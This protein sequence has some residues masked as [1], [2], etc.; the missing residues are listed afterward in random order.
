[1]QS[2][3]FVKPETLLFYQ[4]LSVQ[5]LATDMSK[6]MA[7]V[8]DLKTM[9]ELRRVAGSSALRLENNSERL[10]VKGKRSE[11]IILRFT[12]YCW[13]ELNVTLECIY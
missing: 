3:G 1:M 10:Q 4:I 5:V 2:N 9:V 13:E 6:H 7:L 12:Y 8:A 11:V